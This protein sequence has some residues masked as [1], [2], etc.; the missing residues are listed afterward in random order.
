MDEIR[1]DKGD[2]TVEE[3]LDECDECTNTITG[4]VFTVAIDF[5]SAGVT[6]RPGRYCRDCAEQCAERIRDGLPPELPR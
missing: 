4:P 2:V 3:V 6:E 5:R 1:L